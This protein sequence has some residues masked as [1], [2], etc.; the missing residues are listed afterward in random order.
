M[1][2]NGL[3]RKINHIEENFKF[4]GEG[5]DNMTFTL[6][7]NSVLR[8]KS[9]MLVFEPVPIW[10]ISKGRE[11]VVTRKSP[12]YPYGG[13]RQLFEAVNFKVETE[14]TKFPDSK[15]CIIIVHPQGYGT[16][17][18]LNT[19][20]EELNQEGFEYQVISFQKSRY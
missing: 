1:T 18:D 20:K 9:Y 5:E 10:R 15:Q 2:L 14:E 4:I 19:L 16:E 17:E 3:N 11:V 6:V 12:K 7:F 13:L 8:N